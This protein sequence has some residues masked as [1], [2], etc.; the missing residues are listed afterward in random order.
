M[1][2]NAILVTQKPVTWGPVSASLT[3]VS[4]CGANEDAL[5]ITDLSDSQSV[6]LT[7]VPT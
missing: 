7:I 3:L 1:A 6:E 4:A 2:T 5:R